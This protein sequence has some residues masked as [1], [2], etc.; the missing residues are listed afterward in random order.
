MDS[1]HPAWSYAWRNKKTSIGARSAR[2]ARREHLH[3]EYAEKCHEEEIQRILNDQKVEPAPK[4]AKIDQDVTMSGS[5]SSCQK[6]TVT[7]SGS[8][9]SC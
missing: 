7:M 3:K 6:D 4:K 8:T 9:S 2:F 1:Q 5:A